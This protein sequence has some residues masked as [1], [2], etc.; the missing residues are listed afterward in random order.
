MPATME[1]V[2]KAIATTFGAKQPG[3][4]GF[5]GPLVAGA[6]LQLLAPGSS[7]FNVD[8]VRVAKIQG[9]SNMDS[10]VING[11]VLPRPTKG[12]VKKMDNAKIIAFSCE[13]EPAATETKGTVL[14]ET[15]DQLMNYNTSEEQAMEDLVKTFT[16]CGANVVIANAKISEMAVH[17]FDRA[18]MMV[19]MIPSKFEMRRVCNSTGC[20][21]MTKLQA[22]KP[23]ELG[24]CSH[25]AVEEI[26]DRRAIVFRHDD[27]QSKIATIV[28]R[29]ATSNGLDDLQRAVDNSVNAVKVLLGNNAL[30]AGGGAAEIECAKQLTEFG[31]TQSGM[32]QYAVGKFAECLEIIPHTLAE[33]AG[34]DT[35]EIIAQ[36]YAAHNKEGGECIGIDIEEEGVCD[37][38]ERYVLDS[39]AVK[40]NAVKLAA[41]VAI[42]VLRVD[43]IIMA[44]PAGGP[45]V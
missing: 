39:L 41:D 6:C 33:N 26:G 44:K 3:M 7:S 21:V 4:E 31:E 28:L 43:Q 19:I 12:S 18:G 16:D 14:L 22:A 5:F 1:G 27:V 34:Y 37:M 40:A 45:K 9:G 10:I 25:I 2:G 38:K 23:E 13:V 35:T 17:F 30:C 36:L 42:T 32:E 15:A 20:S 29:G 8:N 11:L 24:S